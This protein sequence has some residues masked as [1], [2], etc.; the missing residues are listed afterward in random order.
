ME[1][2]EVVKEKYGRPRCAS[3]VAAVTDAVGAG[4][5]PRK[6]AATRSPRTYTMQRRPAQFRKRHW[7]LRSAAATPR[8]WRKLKPGETVLDLGSGGGI[9]VLLSARRVGPTAKL[10]ASI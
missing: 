10:T 9:D 4:S 5:A 3:R 1:I 6:A 2:K 8:R 7:R